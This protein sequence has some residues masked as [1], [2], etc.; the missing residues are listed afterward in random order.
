MRCL[1]APVLCALLS[2]SA[3]HSQSSPVPPLQFVYSVPTNNNGFFGCGGIIGVDVALQ[4][5]TTIAPTT[6]DFN[7]TFEFQPIR[8]PRA[9]GIDFPIVPEVAIQYVVPH[10]RYMHFRD[11]RG[12]TYPATNQA[13]LR[14]AIG[15]DTN[16]YDR[17]LW[18]NRT[19]LKLGGACLLTRPLDLNPRR[20]GCDNRDLDNWFVKGL[21]AR[22][23]RVRR[24]DRDSEV[25][26]VQASV[27]HEIPDHDFASKPDT[28]GYVQSFNDDGWELTFADVSFLGRGPSIRLPGLGWGVDFRAGAG[29]GIARQ[30]KTTTSVQGNAVATVNLRDDMAVTAGAKFTHRNQSFSGLPEDRSYWTAQAYFQWR[31]DL[32]V[33]WDHRY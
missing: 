15:Y 29:V 2:V 4:N 30:I 9:A 21:L 18:G 5:C 12:D 26:Y 10:A 33:F 31:P 13:S 17:H 7:W 24:D 8:A 14:F 3:A 6:N 25:A 16:F 1:V 11:S 22:T 23:L 19:M 20:E 28:T 27:Y 32:V